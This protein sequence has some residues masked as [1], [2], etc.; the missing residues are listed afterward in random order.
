MNYQKELEL[1]LDKISTF[2]Y[3]PKLLLHACCA[4][5][6]SYC[7]EY[8]S[9]YFDITIYYYN[10]NIYPDLEYNRRLNELKNFINEIPHKN[11]LE[12][13]ECNYNSNEYYKSIKG[14]ENLGERSKRCC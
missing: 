11:K 2:N 3:V 5:C 4:P 6:S 7:I 14:L 8:L 13:I 9:E 1:I 12:L 10:P